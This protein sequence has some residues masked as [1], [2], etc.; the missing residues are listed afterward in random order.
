MAEGA[1]AGVCRRLNFYLATNPDV[2]PKL[3]THF[4][5]WMA[6]TFSE[7]SI[8]GDI[9][10]ISTRGWDSTPAIL[11]MAMV[12]EDIIDPDQEPRGSNGFAI[13]PKLTASGNALLLI[14]PHT[15][16]LQA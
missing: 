4:E 10:S 12:E 7:G 14:N 3:L 1:D 13:A 9:E 8:G 11:L 15:S 6:L 16:F 5:P 2:K